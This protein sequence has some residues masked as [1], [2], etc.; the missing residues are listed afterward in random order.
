MLQNSTFEI[1]SGRHG[2]CCIST[3]SKQTFLHAIESLK[4]LICLPGNNPFKVHN[5]AV[6]RMR[7]GT[8]KKWLRVEE[9]IFS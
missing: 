5:L 7:D 8:G 4:E 6:T 2:L 9:T 3:A 1:C